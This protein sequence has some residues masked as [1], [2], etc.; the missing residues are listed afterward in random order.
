MR[1]LRL[2]VSAAALV[3]AMTGT[4]FAQ[5]RIENGE[6]IIAEIHTDNG[7]ENAIDITEAPPINEVS[8]VLD[9]VD[10]RDSLLKASESTETAETIYGGITLTQEETDLLRAILALEA[11]YATEGHDGQKAVV[12]VI[13]NRVLSPNWPDTVKDVIYQKG[14]FATVKYLK[15]PYNI[16]GE[17]EDD[18]I[19][20]VLRE[21]ETVLPDTRYVYFS[22]GKSN[23]KDFVKLNHHW[24]SR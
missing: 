4:A 11:D 14:Q 20:A 21:T 12:E 16:P 18:A 19:S 13:F 3:L 22:R 5:G 24:F 1:H 23:G 6:L 9:K 17:H 7:M 8:R 15:K 2:A 10:A